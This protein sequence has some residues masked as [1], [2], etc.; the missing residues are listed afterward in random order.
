M[1]NP[2]SND[3]RVGSKEHLRL[4]LLPFGQLSRYQRKFARFKILMDPMFP[5]LADFIRP[6]WKVIDVGCGFGVT[7]AWLLAIYPDLR[8]LACEPDEGRARVAARVLDSSGEVLS[9]RAQDLPLENKKADAVLCLDMLHYLSDQDLRE[10]LGRARS[11]F[12]SE[13]RLIIRVTIPG[14]RF[15][16][17]RLIEVTKLRVRG[18]KYYFREV[19]DYIRIITD[20]DFKMELVELTAPGSEENWFIARIENGGVQK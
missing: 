5:R 11:V 8:F 7:A 13:G 20:A 16:L 18:V 1:K 14:K 12:P 4:A 17:L 15:R 9:C 19:E 10:F 2:R 6:G 3:Q